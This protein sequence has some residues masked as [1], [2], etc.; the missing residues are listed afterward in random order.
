MNSNKILENEFLKVEISAEGAELQS[1]IN[2]KNKINYLWNG[3]SA[4]WGKKSPVLFPIVG[5]LKNDEYKHNGSTF[6]LSRHGF[7]RD[8]EFKVVDVTNTS[9]SLSICSNQETLLKYPFHFDF[10]I[11]YTIDNNL[12]F[13]KYKV[14]NKGN[15]EM[16]FSVGAHPAFNIPLTSNTQFEDWQ[17]CFNEKENA[18]IYPLNKEGLL[19]TKGN[20]FFNE[21]KVLKLTKEL[22]YTDA[23]VFKNLNSKEIKI[24]S[25]K[26][27]SS[28]TMHFEGFNYF[29]IWSAKNANFICLEPWLG[30][31]DSEDT[32]GILSEKEGINVLE[33]NNFFEASWNIKIL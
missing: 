16:Y 18:P 14:V 22:F 3:D 30:V 17:L 25:A 7:A 1:I 11:T 32:K 26:S 20:T 4:Y 33:P 2:K 19:K 21:T 5:G 10:V 15:D 31:A 9:C 23:L 13:C 12:L 6:S 27:D 24:E 8:M 29:G 28:L